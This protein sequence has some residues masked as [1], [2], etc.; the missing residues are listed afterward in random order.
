MFWWKGFP[1]DN[2]IVLDDTTITV[3]SILVL[4]LTLFSLALLS[5]KRKIPFPLR[6]IAAYENMSVLAGRAIESDQP[7]HIS[8]GS[9][10]LGGE[11][12]LLAIA[13]AELA[14]HAASQ[15]V[16]GDRS[17][18]LTV[19]DPSALPLGQDTLRRVYD[20]R[21]LKAR[22]WP[23]NVHWYPMG[24]RS[25][26]FAAAITAQL[27]DE[28]VSSNLLTGSYGPELALIMA[29]GWRREIPAMAVSDQLT[30]QAVAWVFADTPLIGE[31]IFVSPSY[32]RKDI[33]RLSEPVVM[34]ILRWLLIL[35]LLG[36]LIAAM[37][38]NGG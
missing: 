13:G 28:R 7:L 38:S 33:P 14:Y 37:A 2:T 9:A 10:G 25:L 26:A 36:G 19:A 3:L 1:L 29:A 5:R 24:H 8:L 34:D 21:G 4:L 27:T 22:Y 30:G 12:T 35:V 17:P 32:L 15:V 31:E 6:R 16:I 23:Y 18:L 11:S 20:A